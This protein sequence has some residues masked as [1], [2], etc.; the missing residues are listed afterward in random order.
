M[1]VP[2]ST[3]V[4]SNQ[5]EGAEVALR[6]ARR[7]RKKFIARCGYLL[8]DFSLRRYGA[9]SPETERA[10]ALERK[11]FSEADCGV[12]TT[13]AMREFV[14][15]QYGV[16]EERIRVIPNYV[17]TEAF[18]PGPSAVRSSPRVLFIGR[19]DRQKN[20]LALVEAMSGLD[21]DLVMVGAG[22]LQGELEQLA[23]DRRVRLTMPG[24]LP[25]LELPALLASADLFVL[26][27]LYEGH[28]KVLLEAMAAGVPVL[29]TDVDGISSLLRHGENGYVSG[30]AAPELHEAIREL[31]DAP[32]LRQRLGRAGRQFVVDNYSLKRIA[33][34]ELELVLELAGSG[35]PVSASTRPLPASPA[36]APG[37]AREN[38]RT[39]RAGWRRAS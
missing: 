32:S 35:G 2:G 17:D 36:D 9:G 25:H 12:V 33:P 1:V 24:R 3:V 23:E 30:T 6:A 26:P 8:S 27:S 31:L 39:A 15:D 16:D 10:R 29:G 37:D 5:I 22:S 19:L 21:A 11:V 18:K 14:L 34:L 4:K 20:P 7:W 13:D 28:P 38:G